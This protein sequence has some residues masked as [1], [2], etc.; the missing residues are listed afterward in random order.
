MT[1]SQMAELQVDAVV[2]IAT[3]DVLTYAAVER[4]C[5]PTVVVLVIDLGLVRFFDASGLGS[6]VAIR[7]ASR[8]MGK[9]IALA[10]VPEA[11]RQLMS[12]TE[13]DHHFVVTRLESR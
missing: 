6:L 5:D 7:N 11:V 13:L 4:L 9:T 1:A 8:W 10:R 12:I 3:R 2:D